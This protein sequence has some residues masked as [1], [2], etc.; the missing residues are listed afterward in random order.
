MENPEW[1]NASVYHKFL[2]KMYGNLA[3]A[4]NAMQNKKIVEGDKCEIIE[5]GNRKKKL[6][7]EI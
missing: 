5:V 1:Q 7:D 4:H 3:L 2:S 6:R